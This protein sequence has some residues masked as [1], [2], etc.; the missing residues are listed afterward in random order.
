MPWRTPT[1]RH[2]ALS[3][4]RTSSTDRAMT[5]SI[6]DLADRAMAHLNAGRFAE[7]ATELEALLSQKPD[8]PDMWYNLG[9]AQRRLHRFEEALASY[10][11][12]LD[13][14]VADPQEVHLNRAVV[15]TGDLSRPDEA[16]EELGKALAIA[17]RYFPALLN[18][19]G[20]HEDR[21]D[22][23]A[24]REAYAKALEIEPGDA[25][26]LTRLA[27]LSDIESADDTLVKRIEARIGAPS[28]TADDRADLGFALGQ[29]LDRLGDYDAA[30]A[31]Y[32]AA[33]Q[34]SAQVKTVNS[35]AYNR[36]AESAHTDRLI[37]AFDTPDTPD[38]PGGEEKPLFICGMYRSG[39]TLAEQ[40][41]SRHSRV[42]M[43]GELDL[44]PTELIAAFDRYPE[45][46]ATAG[47]PKLAE[48]RAAYLA[49]LEKRFPGSDIVTDKRPA[50]FR[51]IGL[52]K[53][54]FPGAKIVDT[55]RD[56]I[57]N[58]LSIYFAH[59]GASAPYARDLDD[60]V[61]FYRE[62]R[63]LMAHWQSLWPDDILG[64]D[65]DALV[66]DPEPHIRR[67]LDFAGL[68]FEEACLEPHKGEG[69]VRTLSAWQVRQPLYKKSSGRW[70]N[71][72]SHIAPLI[73]AF[74]KPN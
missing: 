19:G 71:Y 43:G 36:A 16:K 46:A 27:V 15:L 59:L 45:D 69:T 56:P 18:L 54:V 26:V 47:R 73:E 25:L 48:L 68:D 5:E 49:E 38:T 22:R 64:L 7:A 6:A 31:A 37:A 30:F 72:E 32:R 39:S 13:R 1:K 12:A 20:L 2:G 57:D 66:S 62:Y 3:E 55:L 9:Y 34:A 61:H 10:A 8:L 33:N 28:S 51:H 35:F 44:V 74:D 63:R 23:E 60:I 53:H 11:Q 29:I 52:I 50:N 70:R 14:G 65:Y 24:A 42:T 17:P 21:G 4:R 40:I 67:L 41:L 58:G